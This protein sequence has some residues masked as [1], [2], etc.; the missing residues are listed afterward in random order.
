MLAYK[1]VITL[2]KRCTFWNEQKQHTIKL[3]VTDIN[4]VEV[5]KV[6]NCSTYKASP[7]GMH[8]YIRNPKENS[9]ECT[10]SEHKEHEMKHIKSKFPG[11]HCACY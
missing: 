4:L 1:A 6:R 11:F 9:S 10:Q 2:R 8:G 5:K 3:S 7:P